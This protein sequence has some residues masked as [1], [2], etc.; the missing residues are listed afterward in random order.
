MRLSKT[1]AVGGAIASVMAAHSSAQ[2]PTLAFRSPARDVS[3]ATVAFDTDGG[4]TLAMDVYRRPATK[5]QRAVLVFFNR[6]SGAD[7]RSPL[8]DGWARAAASHGLVGVVPDL[9]D[10]NQARDFQALIRYLTSHGAALG[11]DTTAI[12]VYAASGNVS[13]AWPL[14]ERADAGSVK[15][16]VIYYGTASVARFRRDL[17]VLYVRAGLDWPG[18][19]EEIMVIASHAI[20]QNAPLTVLNYPNGYH[21][22]E[23]FNDDDA[24]R[25]VIEQ[26]LSFVVQATSRPYRLAL[27]ARSREAAAAGAVQTGDYHE[28]AAIYAE[29]RRDRPEDARLGLSYGESLLGDGEYRTACALFATLENKGLGPRELGVPAARACAL[30]GDGDAALAWLRSIPTR[31]LPASLATDSAFATIRHRSEFRALFSSPPG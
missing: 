15:A 4:T 13:T 23:L 18:V 24:T 26:T 3:V 16:A 6:A 19:N 11:V 1:A 22:F 12:A 20:A 10:G 28:A 2:T 7:R 8:Y 9:R 27:A 25:A 14:L 30:A 21:G 17:P 31:F 5:R 29:L